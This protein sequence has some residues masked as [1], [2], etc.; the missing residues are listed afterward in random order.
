MWSTYYTQ[1]ETPS[2]SNDEISRRLGQIE[3]SQHSL[4]ESLANVQKTLALVSHSVD[5]LNEEEERRKTFRDKMAFFLFSLVGGG[6]FTWIVRG[7]LD[8]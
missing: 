2:M 8:K 1:S 7:G 5:R 3:N 4:E 6:F